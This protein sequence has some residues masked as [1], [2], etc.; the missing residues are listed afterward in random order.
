M[1]ASAGNKS[2]FIVPM[3]VSMVAVYFFDGSMLIGGGAENCLGA[4][5]VTAAP[6]LA[7]AGEAPAEAE[8]EGLASGV[9]ALVTCA[10][11]GGEAGGRVAAGACAAGA[12]LVAPQPPSSNMSRLKNAT[13][14]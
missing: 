3:L 8:A 13:R 7:A 1:G 5:E 4:D 9:R 2:A 14:I 10:A 12:E 6:W 11:D